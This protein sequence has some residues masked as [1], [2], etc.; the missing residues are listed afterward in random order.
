MTD[1]LTDTRSEIAARLAELE[2]LL[3]EYKQLQ[4]AA[5]AL[6]AIPT[7][8]SNGVTRTR[9]PAKRTATKTR[10]ASRATQASPTAAAT[11][12][13]RKTK[14]KARGGRPKGSGKRAVEALALIQKQPG[15]T[16][17]E[18]A[19]QM[20]IATTYLYRVLPPLQKEGKVKKAGKGWKPT[21]A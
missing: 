3:E 21:G 8:S 11:K 16:I 5:A 18:L 9:R 19:K 17:P 13:A 20:G 12:T 1:L 14:A 7:A 10:P 6:K 15:I 2:P 4:A